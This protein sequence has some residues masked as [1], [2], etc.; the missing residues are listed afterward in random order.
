IL[1]AAEGG[2]RDPARNPEYAAVS[3]SNQADVVDMPPMPPDL[4][5]RMNAEAQGL[6]LLGNCFA[7]P[8]PV[9]SGGSFLSSIADLRGMDPAFASRTLTLVDGRRRAR[10]LER[11]ELGD[12]HLYRLPWRSDLAP[13]QAKQALFLDKPG[14][15]VERFYSVQRPTL[16]ELVT[17]AVV[18]PD[19]VIRWDNT[20]R[21]GLGEPLARGIVRVFEPYAGREVFAGE[22]EIGDRPV[23]LPV[24]L[25]ISRALNVMLE[26]TTGLA[27]SGP[28]N[29]TRT[30]VTADYRIVNNK[31][32][33]IDLEI[34][35]SVESRYRNLQ[36]EESSRPAGRKYGDPAWRFT[37]RPGEDTLRYRLSALEIAE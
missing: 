17:D 15:R 8:I 20:A 4:L 12:Y 24:E 11:E 25:R 36:I 13:R 37:V 18:T 10:V 5:Q 22:A 28:S 34:R 27:R 14:V 6:T 29:R 9:Q 19:L 31:S 35:H 30:P 3:T 26:V 32:V 7:S 1:A 16:T 33:P 23:G 21:A 2:S